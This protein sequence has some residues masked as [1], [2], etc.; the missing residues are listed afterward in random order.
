MTTEIQQNRYDQLVRRV[1]GI[2]GPGSKVSEVLAELFPMIDVENVPGELLILGQT[3]IC[4]GTSSFTSAAAEFPNIGIFNPAASGKIATVTQVLVT[5]GPAATI[6]VGH[7]ATELGTTVNTEV[8]R[9]LRK[10]FANRPVVR[11]SQESSATGANANW[12]AVILGLTIWKLEDPNGVAVLAPGTG[13]EVSSD[14]AQSLIRA[15]FAWRER[16]AETSE[17]ELD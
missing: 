11:V 2:I 6:N 8:F 12:Q 9:D 4:V 7:T 15:S 3:D 16:A 1:G 5:S 14:Q 10:G 13:I 17:L